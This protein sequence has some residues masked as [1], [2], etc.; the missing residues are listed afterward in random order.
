M[1]RKAKP[2]NP[3]HIGAREVL[4]LTKLAHWSLMSR[5]YQYNEFP[6]PVARKG[7]KQLWSRREVQ[8]W[9]AILERYKEENQT[10]DELNANWRRLQK[11]CSAPM[12]GFV[13]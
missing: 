3:D 8:E 9:I 6:L 13:N 1:S 2:Q 12:D 7:K 10:L 11:T 5:M 4:K